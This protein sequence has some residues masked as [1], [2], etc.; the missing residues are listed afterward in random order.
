MSAQAY[1]MGPQEARC[2]QLLEDSEW[3]TGMEAHQ[4]PAGSL[5][6]PLNFLSVIVTNERCICKYTLISLRPAS[7]LLKNA[8]YIGQWIMFA[9]ISAVFYWR[10][11]FEKDK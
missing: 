5:G 8:F 6:H 3:V 11:G 4:A 2:G 7:G 10:F 9:F 1:D